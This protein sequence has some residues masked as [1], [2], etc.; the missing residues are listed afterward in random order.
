MRSLDEIEA[1]LKELSEPLIPPKVPPGTE[2]VSNW[3]RHQDEIRDIRRQEIQIELLL[4]IRSLS[5]DIRS[6][7]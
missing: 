5:V 3:L 1:E 7:I 2:F 6:G 4:D